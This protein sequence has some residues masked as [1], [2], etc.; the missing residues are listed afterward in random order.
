MN[1]VIN[2]GQIQHNWSRVRLGDILEVVRGITFPS[3]VKATSLKHGYVAC[4][5]TTN[6]QREVEWGDL[7]YVPDRYVKRTEQWVRK[8]DI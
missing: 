8:N 4:L 2:E 5:R 6:V 1:Q 3:E 7:W